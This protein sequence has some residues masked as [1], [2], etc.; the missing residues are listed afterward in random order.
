[1]PNLRAE[2][3]KKIFKEGVEAVPEK[4]LRSLFSK[5]GEPIRSHLF[6]HD[7]NPSELARSGFEKVGR[8][9]DIRGIY[10][11]RDPDALQYLVPVENAS[12]AAKVR[13]NVEAI[14]RPGAKWKDIS[15]ATF[16]E[17]VEGLGIDFGVRSDPSGLQEV[18]QLARDNALAKIRTKKGNVYRIL[19]LT[20]ALGGGMAALN[21]L[22]PN[23]AEASPIGKIVT[24][25]VKGPVSSTARRLIGHEISGMTIK[26]VVKGSNQWRYI[27]FEGTDQVMPVTKDVLNDLARQF[28]TEVYTGIAEAKGGAEA[29][30][31]A[32]K[33]AEM[34][35]NLKGTG[36]YTKAETAALEAKHVN[37][38]KELE[39]Q[40]SKKVLIKYR[41][42]QISIPETYA[43]ILENHG[44]AKRAKGGK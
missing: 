23:E 44:L 33:S 12:Y 24:K 6:R 28:G 37:T 41:G 36:P 30:R 8:P 38:I 5:R 10:Y 22:N 7:W 3:L 42:E 11:A 14:P 29:L 9:D 31:M 40:P 1:M 39:M 43:T 2:I 15:R 20:G 26:N 32:I 19:G 4:E 34:R 25:V 35:L 17:D 16:D 18:I 21:R 13:P 27:T